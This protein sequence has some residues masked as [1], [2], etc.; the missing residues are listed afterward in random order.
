MLFL[1]ILI[2]VA[3]YLIGSVSAALIIS[4]KMGMPDPRSYGSGN[5]GASNMLRSGR[6]D[7]ATWTLIGDALKGF[8]VILI[9][10]CCY[11][12]FE[13]MGAGIVAWSA[14][15]VVIGHMY[16]VFFGFKGGKGVATALGVLLGM[17]FWATFWVVLIWLGTALKFKKS[18]LAA[19]IA[20]ICAPWVT[21][22]VLREHGT[23]SWGWAIFVIALL[24]IYRHR[25]NIKRLCQ[26]KELGVSKEYGAAIATG[27]SST[28]NLTADNV[29]NPNNKPQTDNSNEQTDTESIKPVSDVAKANATTQPESKATPIDNHP[30]DLCDGDTL[31]EEVIQAAAQQIQTASQVIVAQEKQI[32][33]NEPQLQQIETMTP[34]KT[35]ETTDQANDAKTPKKTASATRGRKKATE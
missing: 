24:V 32:Q 21:F 35:A 25:D 34:T 14:I 33:K 6:K 16:P 31:T 28:S 11:S 18:S 9:A 17:S 20:A 30:A 7:V 13:S 1:E 12:A 27:L 23:P 2:I 19:L 4:K 26:G 5:P 15:A 8:I 29:P 3:A 10:R 22:I